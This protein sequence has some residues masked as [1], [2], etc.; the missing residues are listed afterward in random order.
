[1]K[2]YI[3]SRLIQ[4]LVVLIGVT[5]LTFIMVNVAPGDAATVMTE[6]ITDQAA[7]DRINAQLGLDKP[8]FV[9]YFLFLR[10]LVFFDF[11]TSYFK[12]KPVMQLII[13][14]FRVTGTLAV[15]IILFALVVGLAM[16]IM[17]ALN[18][19]KFWDQLIMGLSTL[20]MALPSFLLAI[21]LQYI[22][23]LKMQLLPLSGLTSW[24]GYVL[25]SV[26]M[27]MICAAEVARLTRTSMLDVLGQ[28]YMR[29]ATAKGISR[30]R[31]ILVHGLKN[32]LI[33]ILTFLGNSF[34]AILGGAVLVETVFGL[35]GIGRLLVDAIMQRDTPIIQGV[36][37]Y[38]AMIF[39][40]VN[41][42]I[43]LFYGLIDPR[44]RLAKDND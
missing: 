8:Y 16:G 7:I 30:Q 29:T 25:P 11:G 43:D 28:D 24:Q 34:K 36:T 14:G 22:F 21:L 6:K 23:G 12:Y 38:I 31:I 4:T 20:G 26:T 18:R 1:M 33:P 42:G 19:G 32:A 9:Q 44:I 13:E 27:G 5:L 40:L 2:K 15:T 3:R 10:N 17:A 37:V 41:L 39:V 35:N